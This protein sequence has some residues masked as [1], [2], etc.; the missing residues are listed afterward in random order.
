[1]C[2]FRRRPELCQE[3]KHF[4]RSVPLVSDINLLAAPR[5]FSACPPLSF[6]LFTCVARSLGVHSVVDFCSF[7]F[8]PKAGRSERPDT[9][10]K[11]GKDKLPWLVVY[12]GAN[13]TVEGVRI[14]TSF[15]IIQS[16]A[17]PGYGYRNEFSF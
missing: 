11:A 5:F 17:P 2:C 6:L 10:K 14:Y 16:V 7:F 4:C 15:V 9:A 8:S 3:K 1:M 13:G 12:S